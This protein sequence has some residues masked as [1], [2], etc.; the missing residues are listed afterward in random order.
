M[1]IIENE[2]EKEITDDELY[3]IIYKYAV[4]IDEYNKYEIINMIYADLHLF[5]LVNFGNYMV[6]EV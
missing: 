4:S 6:Y 3:S 1:R 5:G 2:I